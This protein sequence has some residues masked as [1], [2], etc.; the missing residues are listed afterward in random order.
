MKKQ[1]KRVEIRTVKDIEKAARLKANGW[2][3]VS[4]NIFAIMF[5]K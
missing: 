5:E 2:R 1:Y 3:I 4:S